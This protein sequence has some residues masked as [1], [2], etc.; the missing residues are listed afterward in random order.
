MKKN[1]YTILL[2][3]A[4]GLGIYWLIRKKSTMPPATTPPDFKNPIDLIPPDF[5][6]PTDPIDQKFISTNQAAMDAY[7]VKYVINGMRKFGTVPNTI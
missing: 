1:D 2:L 7:N 3:V 6:H 4:A 5:K